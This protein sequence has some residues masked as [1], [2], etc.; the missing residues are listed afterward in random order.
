MRIVTGE[1]IYLQGSPLTLVARLNA[2]VHVGNQALVAA[3]SRE[4]MLLQLESERVSRY[5][6][7]IGPQFAEFAA[8]RLLESLEEEGILLI[9]RPHAV[10]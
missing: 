6:A 1:G 9:Q 8:T 4:G 10:H 7:E 3:N 5:C 2:F